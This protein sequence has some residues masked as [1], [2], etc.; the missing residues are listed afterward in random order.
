MVTIAFLSCVPKSGASFGL[1]VRELGVVNGN[2]GDSWWRL[3]GR[4]RLV[5]VD[6]K[7]VGG[8]GLIFCIFGGGCDVVGGDGRH[9]L[10]I[11]RSQNCD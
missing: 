11:D 6:G 1:G 4:W 5:S 10:E 2:G 3:I 7:R 9:V 8:A